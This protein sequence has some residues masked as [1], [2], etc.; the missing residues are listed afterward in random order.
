MG[1]WAASMMVVV[2]K[3]G[4]CVDDAQIERRRLPTLELGIINTVVN[5]QNSQN[6]VPVNSGCNS[7]RVI[8]G[9]IPAEFEFRSAFRQNGV[10]KLAG[11]SAKFYSYGIPGIARILPDSSR[12]QWG[13]VKTSDEE[14]FP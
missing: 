10:I 4:V 12:N 2:D 14:G 1:G 11:P 13:T 3:Q 6:S 5:K 9:T 8:P 7:V